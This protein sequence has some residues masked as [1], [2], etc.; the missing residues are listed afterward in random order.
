M[1]KPTSSP[2]LDWCRSWWPERPPYSELVRDLEAARERA[3]TAEAENHVLKQMVAA[4]EMG[5]SPVV[6]EAPAGLTYDLCEMDAVA[7]E[8]PHEPDAV[9]AAKR[10]PLTETE[11][12]RRA[13]GSN[14]QELIAACAE[15][16]IQGSTERAPLN[17][18]RER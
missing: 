18:K 9:A 5:P 14:A 7:A 10:R 8:R 11:T 2:F 4:I 17:P 16:G 13:T 12:K 15:V 1:T 3:T 6:V